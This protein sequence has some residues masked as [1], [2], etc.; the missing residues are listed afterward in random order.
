[1]IRR[2]CFSVLA[3]TLILASSDFIHCAQTAEGLPSVW[4]LS[5]WE[6]VLRSSP[7]QPLKPAALHAAG[8]EWESFQIALRSVEPV[9]VL[10]IEIRPPVKE[11]G[12]R[13]P[14]AGIRRYRAHQ[15]HVTQPTNRND[16]FTAG[17]YPDA[18]IPFRIPT[19]SVPLQPPRFRAVPFAV[20][21]GETHTFWVDI[22]VPEGTEPGDYHGEAIVQL[23][24]DRRVAVPIALYV[25]PFTLPKRA[26]MKTQFGSP[27]ARILSWYRHQVAAGKLPSVPD[28]STLYKRCAEL[29]SAHRCNSY[30]PPQLLPAR[31]GQDGSFELSEEQA[32]GLRAF[33]RSSHVN[34]L[35]VPAPR[36]FF[37]NP[38]GERKHI[39][40]YMRSWDRLLDR[41]GEPELLCYT[42]LIDEPNDPEAYAHT[43][44]WGGLIRKA[45]SR[46]KVLVTEQ[47]TP[48]NPAWG[49]LYGAVDIWVPLF[50][51]FDP[52]SAAARQAQGEAIWTYTALCQGKPTPWWH[53]D[54]P[55]L[56]YRIPCWIAWSYQVQG[57]LYWGGLSY[58]RA[59]DDPWTQPET[60]RTKGKHPRVFN[61]EG[62]LLYPAVAV[63]F[64]GAVPSMRLKAIRDGL[65]DFDYL[66][67]LESLGRRAVG[68]SLVRSITPGW[69]EWS[70]TPSRYEQMRRKIGC[71]I[72]DVVL[73]RARNR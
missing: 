14:A 52:Q 9:R 73:S 70:T 22:Y 48:Q 29:T 4:T 64:H 63:G 6:R 13:I 1:M 18:L 31:P 40:A 7:A 33:M 49:N 42:Y 69:Y 15:L 28:E 16:S 24:G 57:L 26:A 54:Y 10:D 43:R 11:G 45:K 44:R 20:P 59:V 60:Y 55:L 66:V 58:W 12:K 53:L 65:E 17:W 34:A 36:R 38:E 68:E 67:V 19:E 23:D 56:N 25:W 37:K 51:L 32:A 39:V 35:T 72:K 3:G 5:S 46:V 27:A 50:S 71:L 8:N 21:P 41:V 2:H 61:G 62:S 30:P 47:T